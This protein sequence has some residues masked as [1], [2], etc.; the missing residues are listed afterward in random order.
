MPR[1]MKALRKAPIPLNNS[2]TVITG[3][4][5]QD[6]AKILILRSFAYLDC[7]LEILEP[8]ERD[9]LTVDGYVGVPLTSLLIPSNTLDTAR[10]MLG[11]FIVSND[12]EVRVVFKVLL[13]LPFG[14]LSN[15]RSTSYPH[16]LSLQT[17]ARER[18]FEFLGHIGFAD[19]FHSTAFALADYI[20]VAVYVLTDDC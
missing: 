2:L 19:R 6:R 14:V 15:D 10:I 9:S 5:L 13:D 18:G 3:N 17:S 7:L 16:N 4:L 11:R 1:F 12:L 8:T 20:T